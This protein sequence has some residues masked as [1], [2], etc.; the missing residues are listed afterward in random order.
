MTDKPLILMDMDGPLVA[1]ER[2]VYEVCQAEGIQLHGGEVTMEN[3]C[4][5]HRFM[6][7]CAEDKQQRALMRSLVEAEGWFSSL[8]PTE[9]AVEG[10]AE[11]SEVADVWIC[12]KPLEANLSCRDEKAAWVRDHLGPEWERKLIITPNKGMVNGHVLVDDAIKLSWMAYA[13]WKPVVFDTPWNCEGS[14][15]EPF[16]HWVWEDGVEELLEMCH[17]RHPR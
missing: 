9:G 16:D 1:F 12:T 11:L 15:W 4:T 8:E 7:E 6:A 2:K 17:D 13:T 3:P 10:M 5:I 14:D